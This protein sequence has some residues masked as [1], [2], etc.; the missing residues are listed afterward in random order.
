[1]EKQEIAV[2]ETNLA[3]IEFLGYDDIMEE[4][5]Q[6]ANAMKETE[7][8][9]ETIKENKAL[10]AK[11]RA[12]VRALDDERKLV[13]KQIMTPYDELNEKINNIKDVLAEGEQ[14]VNAQIKAYNE[15]ERA[16]RKTQI[17]ALFMNYQA[18]YKAPQWLTFDKYLAKNPT[19]LTN[20]QTSNKRIRETIVN[21]FETFEKDYA[22]LKH[23]VPDKEERSAVLIA[24]AKNGFNMDEAIMDY[25]QMIAEKERLEREQQRV[26]EKK[27]PEIVILTGNEN[28]NEK[29][30]DKPVKYV[31]I[32]VT[33]E[34]LNRLDKLDIEYEEV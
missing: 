33:E 20:K 12:R 14:H 24:Y 11:V 22:R 29:P 19:V 3:S 7:V 5:Q 27:A 26:K 23:D 32:K 1:M 30:I 8:T 28:K 16:I 4:A 15:T 13:K 6:L 2:I 25:M 10:L 17:N 18:S 31:T 21:Y 9:P 34:T